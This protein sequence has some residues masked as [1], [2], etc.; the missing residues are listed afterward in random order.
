M[1]TKPH[2]IGVVGFGSL[3]QY[4]VAAILGIFIATHS[5]IVVIILLLAFFVV[6]VMQHFFS[7]N[8]LSQRHDLSHYSSSGAI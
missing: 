5:F 1:S 2:K 6:L 4:L 8:A 7:S 3:G